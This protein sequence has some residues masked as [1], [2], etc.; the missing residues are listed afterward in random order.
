MMKRIIVICALCL[1]A[2]LAVAGCS[3]KS[4]EEKSQ[5][6]GE[7]VQ[8]GKPMNTEK[9]ME[10]YLAGG[11]FW[12]VEGYFKQVPGVLETFVGYVNGKG[13]QTSYYKI[14]TTGHA[15]ALKLVYDA[16]RIHLAEIL[17]HYFRII[18]PT[19]LNRQGNDVGTQYRTGIYYTDEDQKKVCLEAM[20]VEQKKHEKPLVVELEPLKNYVPAENSHQDYLEKNPRGYCHIDLSL[21]GKPLYEKHAKP[22]D[23]DLKK[24]LSDLEYDVTQNAATERPYTSQYHRVGK[25]GIY[26][27]VA[28]GQPM[29]SS[30]DKY[31]AGCGWPSFT[32]PITT[33]AN[34]YLK[35]NS[36][37]IDRVEVKSTDGDSHLGHVFEDGPADTGGLRYCI[38]GASLRFIPRGKMAEEGYEEYLPYVVK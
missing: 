27:D 16:N 38:N 1:V 4:G 25:A 31:D 34:A 26:V 7:T 14:G 33:G 13:E 2:I 30:D 12:G 3:G 5:P 20:A 17:A 9:R 15:E 21:A 29:Y 18:D 32:M 10:I 35:D 8:E 37:G 23:G 11:C 22:G 19:S 36:L 28:T 6:P 24:K